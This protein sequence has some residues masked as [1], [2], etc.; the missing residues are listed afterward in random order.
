MMYT[1]GRLVLIGALSMAVACG[2]GSDGDG[3]GGEFSADAGAGG[4]GGGG[5]DGTAPQCSNGIDDDG[6]GFIDGFDPECTG[7]EDDVEDSFAT[8]IPGDNIDAIKQ[9]CFFDGDSGHGNDGCLMH[10]CCLLDGPCPAELKPDQFDPNDCEVAQDCIDFCAP[11]TPPGC[12]CFGCCTVCND[13][14]CFDIL[15]NPAVAPDCTAA[16]A[17]NPDVCPTCTKVDDCT[18]PGDNC[19]DLECNLCPGQDLEDLPPECEG[20]PTCPEGIEACIDDSECPDG[21]YCSSGCC[22]NVIT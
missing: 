20:T 8:G 21:K 2:G 1:A 10:T 13:D 4:G 9:D 19:T 5:G 22:I 14:G 15:T 17:G 12:D 7:P 16:E 18:P 11:L 3:E 6:D